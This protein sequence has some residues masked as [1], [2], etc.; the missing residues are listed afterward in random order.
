MS[1]S[2]M[3]RPSFLRLPAWPLH[4]LG[5]A[6]ADELLLGGQRVLPGKAQESGFIFRYPTLRRALAAMFGHPI[7][8]PHSAWLISLAPPR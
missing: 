3:H 7:E 8:R 5:G 4:K 1:D 2:I 6:F